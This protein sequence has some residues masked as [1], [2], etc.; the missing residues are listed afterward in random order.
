[1]AELTIVIKPRPEL[2]KNRMGRLHW[3]SAAKYIKAARQDAYML[4]LEAI[5]ERLPAEWTIPLPAAEIIVSQYYAN[6]P[7]DYDGLAMKAAPSID[8]IVDAGIIA[9]DSPK[10][11]KNYA[12]QHFKVSRRDENQIVICV[13]IPTD[14]PK[15]TCWRCSYQM[16][17]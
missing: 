12:L 16:P 1:L 17:E 13:R 8:G 4:A 14:K 5:Q 6:T 7:L 10:C 9:D 2:S 15:P 3:S 11:I